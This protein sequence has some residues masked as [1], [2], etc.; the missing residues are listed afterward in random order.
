MFHEF[1]VGISVELLELPSN[2]GKLT[3]LTGPTEARNVDRR[4]T[5]RTESWQ[6]VPQPH[7]KLT[8][9][10]GKP[11]RCTESRLM[12]TEGSAAAQIFYGRSRRCMKS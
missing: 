7:D 12:S 11:C 3:K 4:S 9:V 10:Y 6:E 1:W 8:Q 5:G 2:R